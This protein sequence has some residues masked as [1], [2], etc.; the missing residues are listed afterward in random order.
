MLSEDASPSIPGRPLPRSANAR[1]FRRAGPDPLVGAEEIERRPLHT[2][3]GLREL[4]FERADLAVVAVPA[5][6]EDQAELAGALRT[7]LAEREDLS[8]GQVTLISLQG[9]HLV[10]APGWMVVVASEKQMEPAVQAAIEAALEEASL[11]RLEHELIAAWADTREVAPLAV[12]ATKGSLARRDAFGQHYRALVDRRELHAR[13]GQRVLMPQAYP[14]TL[15][16]QVLERVRDRLHVEARHAA[17]DAHL[18]A[19]FEV[20]SQCAERLSELDHARRGHQLEVVIIA[21]LTL[22]SILWLIEALSDTAAK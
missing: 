12:R 1:L 19:Q 5:A 22:Q 14:P 11:A 2:V 9:A 7:A 8:A 10:H 6:V 16:S 13:L 21:L 4:T 15:T 3:A 17:L 20:Q 18:E